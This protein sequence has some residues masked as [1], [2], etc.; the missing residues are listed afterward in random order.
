MTRMHL[1]PWVAALAFVAAQP[2]Q[3]V[4]AAQA[5]H[6]HGHSSAPM[7]KLQLNAGQKWATDAALRQAMDDI[8]QAMAVAMPLIHKG[9]FS[10]A[11]YAA[12]AA[13]IRQ[14]VG[15][16]IEHCKLE[17]KA[18]AMLHLVLAELMAGADLMDGEPP[19]SHHDGAVRVRRALASYGKFF[20]HS[21]WQVAP[22]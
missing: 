3:A 10:Q 13:T 12:L 15:Y 14:K 16:A 17:A 1:P 2:G 4:R 7:H 18:D 20:Q 22:A 8:N 9:R 21:D 19:A 6:H 11:D 5:P